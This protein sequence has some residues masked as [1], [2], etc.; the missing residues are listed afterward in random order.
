[1]TMSNLAVKPI[2]PKSEKYRLSVDGI[3]VELESFLNVRKV[4]LRWQ[5]SLHSQ[6]YLG[7][8]ISNVGISDLDEKNYSNSG[9]VVSINLE[10]QT[11]DIGLFEELDSELLDQDPTVGE[12]VPFK[13]DF[14][15]E[16]FRKSKRVNI[17]HEDSIKLKLKAN[18]VQLNV[19]LFDLSSFGFSFL[20]DSKFS[21]G[22]EVGFDLF[23]RDGNFNGK[24]VITWVQQIG[25]QFKTGVRYVEFNEVEKFSSNYQIVIRNSYYIHGTFSKINYY[26][27]RSEFKILSLSQKSFVIQVE[28][29]DQYLLPGMKLDLKF[30]LSTLNYEDISPTQATICFIKQGPNG[31]LVVGCNI[32]NM[33]ES[34]S[35]N[36]S[37]Y[38]L[39]FLDVS[40]EEVRN[41]G[42]NV[43]KIADVFTFR[44]VETHSDYLE[45]LK[46]RYDAYLAAGKVDRSKK[47]SDMVATLDSKSRI[48]M[49]KH[50]GR[51]IASVAISFPDSNEIILDTEKALPNGYPKEIPPKVKMI[52][53][54][55]LCTHSEYRKGDLL[56]RVFEH[57]YKIFITSGRD[58]IITSSDDKL[59]PLYSK[60]GFQKTGLQYNHLAL[61]G[62]LHH[63]IIGPLDVCLNVNKIS[64]MTW[65]YIY[66]SMY[67]DLRSKK[68]VDVNW[69]VKLKMTLGDSL[70]FLV[71]KTLSLYSQLKKLNRKS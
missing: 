45:V 61:S 9:I 2:S 36:L 53:I 67:K 62:L 40:P 4:R 21:Q 66:G 18:G 8:Y 19:R 56:H 44:Y 70:L 17:R 64:L 39:Q 51:L 46:L 50:Q 1:M 24:A 41:A 68:L 57:V 26:F 14:K 58:Y 5:N 3:S 60:L 16:N 31:S 63:I 20:S 69:Y 27:E 48:L 55:R 30:F 65:S 32:N 22:M 47:P 10:T 34:L 59:W 7:C 6:I 38:L 52:E 12:V 28:K 23:L 29:S 15:Y 49:V 13:T 42:F 35:L 54:S 33:S 11:F 43:S 37:N 25:T 71:V